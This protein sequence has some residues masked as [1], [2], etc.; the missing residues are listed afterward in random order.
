VFDICVVFPRM[1]TKKYK[2]VSLRKKTFEDLD[3]LLLYFRL[4]FVIAKDSSCIFALY[5]QLLEIY[6]GIDC[7]NSNVEE[8]ST[9]VPSHVLFQTFLFFL[10]LFLFLFHFHL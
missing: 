6:H 8:S 10:C 7:K 3:D 9:R 4:Y 5:F 1:L 2:I